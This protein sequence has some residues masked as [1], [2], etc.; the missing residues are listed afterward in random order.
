MLLGYFTLALKVIYIVQF[1]EQPQ[2]QIH[3]HIFGFQFPQIAICGREILSYNIKLRTASNI[4][5]P[6]LGFV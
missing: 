2:I 4:N 1:R 5:M 6:Y 3:L